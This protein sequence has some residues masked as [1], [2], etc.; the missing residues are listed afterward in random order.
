MGGTDPVSR[1][2]CA[3]PT[4]EKGYLHSPRRAVRD[5]EWCKV[6]PEKLQSSMRSASYPFSDTDYLTRP[7]SA[8]SVI[9]S[10]S[11]RSARRECGDPARKVLGCSRRMDSRPGWARSRSSLD[12]ILVHTVQSQQTRGREGLVRISLCSPDSVPRCDF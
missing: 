6:F 8:L 7:Q 12:A 2:I 10:S 1:S 11:G 3:D 5:A 9:V 4:V